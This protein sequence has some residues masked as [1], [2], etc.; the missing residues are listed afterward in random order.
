MG[1]VGRAVAH[2]LG[3][4]R[5]LREA[6]RGGWRGGWGWGSGASG[7]AVVVTAV[8]KA[9]GREEGIP[10][11]LPLMEWG[12]VFLLGKDFPRKTMK[13]QEVFRTLGLFS[14]FR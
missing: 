1:A 10:A 8:M 6:W 4:F 13:H 7:R 12:L 5:G 11:S 9:R 3:G 14:S 2:G